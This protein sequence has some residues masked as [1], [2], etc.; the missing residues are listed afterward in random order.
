M[1]ES[2]IDS[3]EALEEHFSRYCK[4]YLFRGQVKHYVDDAGH[5]SIPTSFSRQGCVPDIMFKWT[6][7]AKAMIRAFS[8]SSYFDVDLETSQAILQHYGWRSF[9]VDLT[10]SP[11]IACWFAVNKYEERKCIHIG[12]NLYEEPVWLVHKEAK[13]ST[14]END[15]HI[16]TIDKL[17]LESLGIKVHDLTL[18]GGDE[19]RLRFEAQQACLAGNLKDRL[20]PQAVISHIEVSNEV[21]HSY[22]KKHGIGKVT[23]VFPPKEEDFILNALLSLPWEKM[24]IDSPIPVFRRGLEIPDYDAKFIKH[25]P[26]EITLFENFWVSENREHN[27][28]PFKSAICYKLP[29]F[30]YYASTNK[31]FDLSFVNEAL[32]LHGNFLIEIDGLIKIIENQEPYTYEKGIYVSLESDETVSISGLIVEH[33]GNLV[34]GVG[35]NLGWYYKPCNGNWE[36]IHHKEQCPCNNNLRHELQFSLLRMLNE[37]LKNDKLVKENSLCYRHISISAL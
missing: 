10:K 2:K 5:V 20:P 4:G 12:E 16:Y 14:G 36:R 18:L 6:H 31:K 15:G 27:D 33:P 25:I 32:K 29:Q 21:L 30:S 13:Y 8:G 35:L 23:D 24:R 19:G 9:Y 26:P 22:Y 1:L 34:Q 17:A 3:L 7:Y 11:H 37:A 28:S